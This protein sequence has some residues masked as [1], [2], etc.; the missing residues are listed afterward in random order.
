[1]AISQSFLFP[2]L[3]FRI[4]EIFSLVFPSEKSSPGD[5]P[6][7]RIEPRS[8]ALQANSLPAKPPGKP[9][10][11]LKISKS[12]I[13]SYLKYALVICMRFQCWISHAC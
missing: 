4:I 7:S 12:C 10:K 2:E 13:A 1:M 11:N 3:L 9:Q 6:S 5:L 8:P